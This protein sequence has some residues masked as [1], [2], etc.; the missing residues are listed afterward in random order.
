MPR[1]VWQNL[2]LTWLAAGVVILVLGLLI[3]GYW[4]SPV[5]GWRRLAALLC[6]TGA[7]ALLA[8]CLLDPL[9]T[10]SMP[11]KGENEVVVLVDASASLDL[12][13][14]TGSEPRAAQVQKALVAGNDDAAWI[15]ALGVASQFCEFG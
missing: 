5:R 2:N 12:A 7:L 1:I 10:R 11:K 15:R 3:V 6:K 13:E 8:L 9:W 14:S 4:R